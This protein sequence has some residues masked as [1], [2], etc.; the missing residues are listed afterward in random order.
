MWAK[1]R[2]QISYNLLISFH[3]LIEVYIQNLVPYLC[4]ASCIYRCAMLKLY[5]K[6]LAPYLPGR[7]SGF[8]EKHFKVHYWSALQTISSLQINQNVLVQLK[9]V[10]KKYLFP[11]QVWMK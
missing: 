1:C 8:L 5:R 3:L 11:L 10:G 9:P 2:D 4:W 7:F 6:L